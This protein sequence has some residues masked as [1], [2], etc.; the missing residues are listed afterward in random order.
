MQGYGLTE[1]S[2]VITSN[3]PQFS[4]LGS[5]GKPIRNMSIRFAEDGEIEATGPG[6][7]LGYFHKP[8][9]TRAAFTE[10]G[11][12][13]TGDIGRIDEDGFLYITDRKKEMFKTSGGKYIAP[14][15]IEQRIRAS[16]FV[17]QPCWLVANE[18]LLLHLSFRTS[19][20]WNPMRATRFSLISARRV[21]S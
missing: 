7:M 12:F 10:D 16:R 17:S 4:R 13:R 19:R 2:P 6:V 20:C 9:A 15:P 18:S 11:W 3:N 14:S 21:L 1:T 5:V 8:D